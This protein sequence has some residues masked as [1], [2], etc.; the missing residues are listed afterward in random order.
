MPCSLEAG[1]LL[2]DKLELVELVEVAGALLPALEDLGLGV[3]GL[4]TIGLVA[5]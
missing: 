1:L 2:L 5:I 3:V 4:H